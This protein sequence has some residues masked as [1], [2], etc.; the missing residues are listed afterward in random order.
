MPT[1]A[2]ELRREA[3]ERAR[4]ILVPSRYN[5]SLLIPVALMDVPAIATALLRER[6]EALKWVFDNWFE[7]MTKAKIEA[8]IAQLEKNNV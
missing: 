1:D 2:A 5:P 8:E 4:E 7:P 6:A 3:E